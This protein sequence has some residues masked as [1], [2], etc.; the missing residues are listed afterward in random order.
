M[1]LTS[2]FFINYTP[3]SCSVK[4]S[5]ISEDVALMLIKK[6]E[7]KCV[8]KD[9]GI[10]QKLEEKIGTQV[11]VTVPK[12]YSKGDVILLVSYFGPKRKE[13]EPITDG[14]LDYCL[15]TIC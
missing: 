12:K 1:Y 15:L 7:I 4:K 11:I 5:S 3:A 2:R 6:E 14:K 13:S 10:L 9:T 8:V